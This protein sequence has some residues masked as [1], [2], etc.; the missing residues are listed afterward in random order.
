MTFDASVVEAISALADGAATS[1]SLDFGE[2]HI[3]TSRDGQLHRIDLTGDAY[4]DQPKRKTGAIT[5]RDVSSFAQYWSK[6]SVQEASEIYADRA[7]RKVTAVLDAHATRVAGWGQ[8]RLVLALKHSS[9]WL[10]WA[11]KDGAPMAQEAFAE[12]LEDNRVDIADP[13]A[14]QMLEIASS[15]QASTKAEFQAGIRLTDGQRK[16]SYVE[17]TTAS[18][19]TRGD[20]TIPEVITLHVPVFEG[21]STADVLTARFRY[22]INGGKLALHYVL[23][24]PADVIAA[25][26]EGVIDDITHQCAAPVLR[27]IPA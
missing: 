13:P 15:L 11:G 27:G 25:A 17:A 19:G 23:D 8:H 24:R 21:A 10:A 2:Y 26:F 16:L 20:L 6:H 9:A 1:E 18:A 14:A 12:F 7:E 4:R 5:V 22:R 3:V